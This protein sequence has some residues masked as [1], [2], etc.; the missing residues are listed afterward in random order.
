MCS[1]KAVT[2]VTGRSMIC[3]AGLCSMQGSVVLRGVTGSGQGVFCVHIVIYMYV[4]MYIYIYTH[5]YKSRRNDYGTD[6]S[7]QPLMLPCPS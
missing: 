5:I 1:P 4:C 3:G 6:P 2:K 7:L